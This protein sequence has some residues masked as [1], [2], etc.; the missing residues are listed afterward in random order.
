MTRAENKASRLLQI[1]ALLLAH[2]RGS[3]R[4]RSPAAWA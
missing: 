3:S 4:P 2:P 1:E